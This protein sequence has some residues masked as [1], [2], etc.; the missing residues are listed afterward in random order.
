MKTKNL[1]DIYYICANIFANCL[2][3]H[4]VPRTRTTFAG[5]VRYAN[6]MEE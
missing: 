1:D 6:R 3:H 2:V 4:V 5:A